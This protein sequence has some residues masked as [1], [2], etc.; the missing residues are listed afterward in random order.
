[1]ISLLTTFSAV[2]GCGV[3]PAGHVNELYRYP[4]GVEVFDALES[5]ARSALLPDAVTLSILNQLER[6]T[7]LKPRRWVFLVASG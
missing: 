3:L 6:S 1:M 7:F 4:D 5:K 2:F